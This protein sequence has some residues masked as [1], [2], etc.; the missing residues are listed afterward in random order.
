MNSNTETCRNL[1]SGNI[2]APLSM[3][4]F[5]MI[6]SSA[7][8]NTETWSPPLSPTATDPT[9]P[10]SPF[11]QRCVVRSSSFI[12]CKGLGAF[13]GALALFR[14]SYTEIEKSTFEC[15]SVVDEAETG[16][17]KAGGAILLT[18]QGDQQVRISKCTFSENRSERGG[19]LV[20]VNVTRIQIEDSSF[21]KNEESGHEGR[22]RQDGRKEERGEGG[23]VWVCGR[24]GELLVCGVG[25]EENRAEGGG[26]LSVSSLARTS[27]ISSCLFCGN[28]AERAGGVMLFGGEGDCVSIVFE[29]CRFVK[30]EVSERMGGEEVGSDVC[31]VDCSVD[32]VDSLVRVEN[33]WSTSNT[34]RIGVLSSEGDFSSLSLLSTSADSNEGT[35]T[36]VHVTT[37][38]ADE[39]GCGSTSNTACATVGG[40]VKLASSSEMEI[41]AGSGSFVETTRI[42]PKLDQSLSIVGDDELPTTLITP[43]NFI[44]VD[45]NSSLTLSNLVIHP[46]GRFLVSSIGVISLSSITIAGKANVF[47]DSAIIQIILSEPTDSIHVDCLTVENIS[48]T[49]SGIS[50]SMKNCPLTLSH[51][52]S[53]RFSAETY[54]LNL[55]LNHS[56]AS[57]TDITITTIPSSSLCTFF[58]TTDDCEVTI[59]TLKISE[60]TLFESMFLLYFTFKSSTATIDS[61]S[62]TG[63]VSSDDTSRIFRIDIYNSTTTLQHIDLASTNVEQST[64]SKPLYLSVMNNSTCRVSRLHLTNWNA[65]TPW[66]V[67]ILSDSSL[68]LSDFHVQNSIA[69]SRS[70]LYTSGLEASLADSSFSDCSNTYFPGGMQLDLD[71]G[72]LDLLRVDFVDCSSTCSD[73]SYPGAVL[74]RI[75]SGTLTMDSCSFS[76]CS[77]TGNGG[78]L[79]LD[80]TSASG[81]WDYLLKS[82]EF[83]RG[84]DANRCGEGKF[85]NDVFVSA[86][87]L[88]IAV[89]PERWTGSFSSSKETDLMGNYTSLSQTMSLIPFLRGTGVFVRNGGEDTASCGGSPITACATVG[90]AVGYAQSSTIVIHILSG[91]FTE[92]KKIVLSG[93]E[94]VSIE[95][96][97][98]PPPELVTPST[99]I[100]ISKSCRLTLTNVVFSPSGTIL[101]SNHSDLSVS[102]ITISASNQ[103]WDTLFILQNGTISFSNIISE[104]NTRHYSLFDISVLRSADSVNLEQISMSGI[105][106]FSSACDI[107][108]KNCPVTLR[109]ITYNGNLNDNHFRFLTLTSQNSDVSLSHATLKQLEHADRLFDLTLNSTVAIFQFITFEDIEFSH[110]YFT[111]IATGGTLQL[112]DVVMK[113]CQSADIFVIL[114]LS[115]TNTIISRF[116]FDGDAYFRY[117]L[118]IDT[119]GSFPHVS[120]ITHTNDSWVPQIYLTVSSTSFSLNSLN[121]WSVSGD[122]FRQLYLELWATNCDISLKDE[123]LTGSPNDTFSL[124]RYKLIDCDTSYERL[125][126]INWPGSSVLETSVSGGSY[127]ISDINITDSTLQFWH[128]PSFTLS[129]SSSTVTINSIT[130][131]GAVLSDY[132]SNFIG[133]GISNRSIAII[134][135]INMTCTTTERLDDTDLLGLSVEN[136]SS[137][138][139]SHLYLKNWN[140]ECPWFFGASSRSSLI[141]SDFQVQTSIMDDYPGFYIDNGTASLV[142]ASFSDCSNTYYEGGMRLILVSG[143]LNLLRVDFVNCSSTCS[144]S[145]YPGAVLARISSG[146]LTIDSCSFSKCSTTGNGGALRLDLT[147][148]S[149]TWDYLLKSIKFGRGEDAN[150]CGEGKFGNDVFVSATNL[151]I[152][153]TPERWTGSFSSSKETDLMG[154]DT[155]LNQTM[156]L[157]PFLRGKEVFVGKDGDDEHSGVEDFPLRTIFAAFKLLKDEGMTTT[158]I[159][160][161][162]LAV[163]GKTVHLEEQGELSVRTWEEKKG[164]VECS[165]DDGGWKTGTR[166]VVE[167]MVRLEIVSLSFSELEFSGFASPVGINSVFSVEAQSTLSLTACSIVSSHEITHTLAKVS[168]DGTLLV[169]GLEVSQVRFGGKGSVFVVGSK[170]RVEMEGGEVSSTSLEGGAVVWGST[171]SGIEVTE[172]KFVGCTGRQYG[173]L[174]RVS[175]IGCRVSVVKCVFTDCRTVVGMEE[176]RGGEGRVGGG[177]V[178]IKLGARSKSTR[179]LPASSADLSSTQFLHCVLTGP[180]SHSSSL[181]GGSAFAIMSM[182][183]NGRIDFVETEVRNCTCGEGLKREGTDGGV[184]VWRTSRPHTNRRGMRVVGC[185]VGQLELDSTDSVSA[186]EL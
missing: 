3:S 59:T 32:T 33:C 48:S 35:A 181:V 36:T 34:A 65:G 80:L 140:L 149:G 85:G 117:F 114:N 100:N 168:H 170:G 138:E 124:Q 174:I 66:D 105:D 159:V 161:S 79:H 178:V 176:M 162:E 148:A 24:V 158:A 74:A 122:R 128:D 4:S 110:D 67:R 118:I 172:T 40:A 167:A 77:T 185:G 69:N 145:S 71:S 166:R 116:S 47:Y 89:T 179:H 91:V 43:V 144:D 88:E 16:R 44:T 154:N 143:S 153:V 137:C 107:T 90:G 186:S 8:S 152:A 53:E 75:S 125:K 95:G 23:G 184:I 58:L 81:T 96:I 180:A 56:T 50:F 92:T 103:Y 101:A 27:T 132:H 129:I 142:D 14:S 73:S 169:D 42:I 182:E 163:I 78:A 155:T 61:L 25:S 31:F 123:S 70:I 6:N 130:F 37:S 83:G 151:E 120:E 28:R 84:E 64:R 10:I 150:R 160:V 13:G 57:L 119:D 54:L 134:Q 55:G 104:A 115:S 46:E 17:K 113:N 60:I 108:S 106:D 41:R 98:A 126:L 15:C 99:F 139:I 39:T 141:I 131:T 18:G 135:N 147:S 29:F 11:P 183:K 102:N 177:C 127:S 93:G 5:S 87:K 21:T 7:V 19:A 22:R 121:N 26:W 2:F 51:L 164:R 1:L 20:F 30:N 111:V 49:G 86:Q 76:K 146:T 94:Q 165:V 38:G 45:R 175:V 112:S 63:A 82:I 72:S 97:G 133:I 52:N 109:D 68:N 9:R 157:I 173:S 156:S 136:D 62:F 12:S 171:E